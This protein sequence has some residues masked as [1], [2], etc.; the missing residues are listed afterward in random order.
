[1]I[2]TNAQVGTAISVIL[3]HKQLGSATLAVLAKPLLTCSAADTAN[4]AALC[5]R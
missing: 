1:M 4:V 3:A 2:R 5:D